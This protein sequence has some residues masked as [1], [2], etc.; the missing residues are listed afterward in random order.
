MIIY[1][2]ILAIRLIGVRLEFNILP[3]TKIKQNYLKW[4]KLTVC[5]LV[6]TTRFGAWSERTMII[7]LG[8]LPSRSGDY[9]NNLLFPSLFLIY[10]CFLL[11][12]NKQSVKMNL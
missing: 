9:P 6:F 7:S 4:N 5:T 11:S 10:F 2:I 1:I 12:Q 3:C 8:G